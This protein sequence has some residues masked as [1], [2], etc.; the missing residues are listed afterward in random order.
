MAHQAASKL[1]W[2]AQIEAI[3][4]R[5]F[6]D[7]PEAGRIAEVFSAALTEGTVENYSRHFVRFATWCESQPDRP[8]PLPATTDTVLRWLGGDVC[9]GGKVQ[10]RSLRPYLA[11]IN[12]L[13]NDLD[14]DPPAVGRRIKRFKSGLGHLL[15]ADRHAAR[16]YVPAH[17]IERA[18]QCGMALTDAELARPAGRALLQ[19]I[20]A[21]VFTFV[22]FARGGSGAALRAGD[23]RRSDAGLHVTLGKEKTRHAASVSRVLT[24]DTSRIPGLDDLLLRWEAVRGDVPNDASYYALPGQRGFPATQVDAW[25]KLVLD[26]LGAA[27]PAGESWTGHSLRKGAASAADAIGVSLRRICWMGGWSS[28]SSAVKDYIDPTCPC[29][30][31][32]RRYFGWLLP[33]GSPLDVA[34]LSVSQYGCFTEAEVLITCSGKFAAFVCLLRC[35]GALRRKPPTRP[36]VLVC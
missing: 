7:A 14:L 32:G 19:A 36:S 2:R 10:A 24:L 30:D 15:A 18:H 16:T 34:V 13:H 25:L 4:A 31:A 35:A 3:V 9:S 21:T 28:Q 1:P 26:H 6:G 33:A 17:V 20:V 11:A 27:A 8:C 22:F 5:D 23:V 12:T 29:T